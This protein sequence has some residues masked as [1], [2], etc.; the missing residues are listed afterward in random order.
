MRT[1][2]AVDGPDGAPPLVLLHSLGADRSMWRPQVDALAGP[3]RVVR[4]ETRGHGAAPSPPGPYTLDELGQDVLD[5]LDA[6]GLGT[7]HLC[8]LS[9]GGLIA[10]WVAVHQPDRLRSLTVANTAARVGTAQ[11]WKQRIDAVQ[12][13]GLAGIRDDVLARFFAADFAQQHP[14]AFAEAQQAFVAADDEGYA[15][16]CSALADADLR[17]DV[18]AI[19]TPTLVV[20]G[21]LD[22]ATPPGDAHAL[23]D[24]IIG[25]EL[26]VLDDAAHL[27]NLDRP[28]AFTQALRHHL[29]VAER[30]RTDTG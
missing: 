1:A 2:W 8:G 23:H 16:C 4:V 22:V 11:G 21:A 19:A 17:G 5:T 10:L 27:S 24:A 28:D 25:S 12:S 14:A 20:G 6:V 7:V 30:G 26:V 13:H 15:A 3:Y 29:D 9:L 18:G